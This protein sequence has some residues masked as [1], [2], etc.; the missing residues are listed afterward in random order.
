I[1]V[2]GRIYAAAANTTTSPNLR[3]GFLRIWVEE[4]ILAIVSIVETV[5]G[6]RRLGERI[7]GGGRHRRLGVIFDFGSGRLGAGEIA[8]GSG[9]RVSRQAA[10]D[11]AGG[12]IC[13][14]G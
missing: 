11:G 5:P 4:V 2:F 12:R 8:R 7:P 14:A 3:A 6:T 1:G 9:R 13:L 10:H